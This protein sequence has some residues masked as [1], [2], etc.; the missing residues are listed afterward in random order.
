MPRLLA[1]IAAS[2]CLLGPASAA[3]AAEV[4]AKDAPEW[5][6][7]EPQGPTST[8]AIDV[9]EGTWMTVDLAPD[10]SEIVFDL[11]G[12]IYSIPA[13]GGTAKA[14]TSGIAWDMQPR[15][16]PDG[17]WIAF[18]SDRAGGDNIWIMR[19]DGS[20]PTQVSKE[21]FRLVNSPTWAPDGQ[22][23]AGRK[24]FTAERSLGS[25]EI[26]LWH[27]SGGE[28]V[29]LT[30]KPND[31]KDVGEPAFSPDGRYLYS[32]QDVTPGS[33]F[34]YDKDSNAGIY[35]IQRLDRETGET[36]QL[37]GG[38]G[39][40][41]RP[42]PSPDGRSIAYIRRVRFQ[43]TLFVQDLTSGHE[44]AVY[45]A[46]DRDLQETW[47]IHGVYPAFAWSR[48]GRALVFWA[49]GKIRR[50]ELESGATSEVPFRVQDSR[51]VSPALRVPVEVAPERFP[52]KLARFVETSPDGSRVLFQA[53]GKLWIKQLPDGKP[54]RLTTDE[55]GF[56]YDGSWSRDGRHVVYTH[57][58][59]RQLGSVRVVAGA[60]RSQPRVLTTTPGHYFE[61]TFTPDGAAVVYRKDSG[62]VL[63]GPFWGRDPGIYLVP[64]SGGPSRLVTSDG[65]EPQFGANPQRLY[66]RRIG[67]EDRRS[68]VSLDLDGSDER[69]EA[70]SE[71]ATRFAVSPDGKWLAFI[72]RWNVHVTPFV[73]T[74]RALELGP[75]M[76][77]M[78]VT[79][80]S[81]D[82]G[83]YVHWSGDSSRLHWSLGAILFSLP[84]GDAFASLAGAGSE[85]KLDPRSTPIGF[86]VPHGAPAGDLALIG[87]RV[88]TM[89]D[90]EPEIL[91]PGVVL[92]SGNRIVA[93]GPVGEV[94]VPPTAQRID[95]QG[96]TLIPGLIDVH[97]HGPQGSD[98]VIPQQN[99]VNYA[100][101]A[102][103]VTTLHDPSNDTHE[104]FAAAEL[105]RAGL[106][107]AP[108]IFSTGTILY[109]AK[110]AENALIDS[111]DDARRHLRRLQ[112]AGAF[113]VKSY[114]Q[115]RRDQRQQVIAAARE[116][117]MMV[118]PEGGSLL[119]QNL[120]QVVDGHTGVE[121]TVPV[122]AVY[123][124]VV[125]LWAGTEVGY[126]PTLGVAYGGLSGE[127]Y[128]YATTDV[129]AEE[130]LAHFV[131]R[132][133]LD[134]RARRRE[135][136]PEEEY[137]HVRQA[138]VAKRLLDAG[139]SV[140]LGAHGQREGLAAHWEMWMFVQGGM[141]PFEALRA[142]TLDGA[143]YLGLDRDLG[144][145]EVGKLADLVIL[146]ANPL[147]DIRQST[148][149]HRVLA[150]GRLYD[151]RTMDEVAPEKRPRQP[152]WWEKSAAP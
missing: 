16:S 26:W 89:R 52:I 43:S 139:V 62:D 14:L 140:Q 143:K 95:V 67:E 129:W 114:N 93:V 87:G 96:K 145:I 46:L 38:P 66:L 32:S 20:E 2:I 10:G 118:V 3:R 81:S 120:T 151:S 70:T 117:G 135:I 98:Q 80:V 45:H 79:Q 49:G 69:V 147:D 126:T 15:F 73:P 58:D 149:I 136:A 82:A 21:T 60:P 57:F 91:E 124:D 78:P 11:L 51:T 148:K 31:Q 99:W 141:T 134:A 152:F 101:L 121:H 106:I 1:L 7:E 29:R 83:E 6:V 123:D 75:K 142:A 97:W 110:D 8:V 55:S 48:D 5:K 130:P 112:A 41:I 88:V 127:R 42:T 122:G 47:A 92:T 108:R 107:V 27:R 133:I 104:I 64:T 74:G 28:G 44:R 13:A 65:V 77:S 25:G 125:Q 50:L 111:L 37:I 19:R 119:A 71:A 63:R 138:E 86:D 103:G 144:S 24:H 36:V 61:P 12:D 115:P 72:E 40:A 131:P 17:Q 100:S 4:D 85:K 146:D 33:V 54:A 22:W 132:E 18:T 137:N 116:L 102:Y 105:Q 53:L 30:D 84:L 113:S 94:T 59:D 109:G 128:W 76:A 150:N 39:G 9:D 68:L 35:A 56:E 90:G 34:E 23:I